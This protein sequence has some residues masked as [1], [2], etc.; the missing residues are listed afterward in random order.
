L[1]DYGFKNFQLSILKQGEIF[2]KDNKEF[3]PEVD[4]LITE[5]VNGTIKEVNNEGKLSIKNKNGQVLQLV[6]LKYKEPIPIPKKGSIKNNKISVKKE[7]VSYFNA[8]YGIIII[9]FAGFFIG[10]RKKFIKKY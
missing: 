6:T 4:T 9:A 1:F 8:I 5:S 7:Q 2:K 3:F 10:G